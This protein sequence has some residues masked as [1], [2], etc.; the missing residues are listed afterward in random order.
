MIILTQDDIIEKLLSSKEPAIRLKTY[1]Q[2]LNYKYETEEVIRLTE[3]IKETSTVISSLFSYLPKEGEQ[4]KY[5]VYTKWQGAHWILAS[6]ADICYPLGD[7]S[8]IPSRDSELEWLLG[9][10]RWKKFPIIE[11]RKRFCASQDGNGLYS[12]LKLKIYD[13][14]V[15]NLVNRL[16]D[17]QWDDGGWNCDKKPKVIKSSYHESLIPLR[18]LNLYNEIFNDSRVK[19]AVDKCAELFLKRKLFRRLSDNEII[20]NEWLKLHYPPFW[21]YDILMALKV[22]AEANKITDSCCIEAIDILESKRL[23]DGGFPTESK[24][25]QP[26]NIDKSYFSPANWGGVNKRLMNEF[27]TID[28]LYVL[29]EAKRI[30]L[31]Y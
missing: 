15:K 25:F 9:S 31:N 27:V 19:I 26:N 6:L 23:P 18:A 21:H 2:L 30:D 17:Y 12:I 20:K 5:H 22:L 3:N 7:S 28:V 14:R 10:K 4:S 16:V 8:L 1:I 11:D 24:Y 13:R 29:K